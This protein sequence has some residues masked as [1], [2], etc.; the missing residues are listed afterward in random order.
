[1]SSSDDTHDP[2][3]GAHDPQMRSFLRQAAAVLAASRGWNDESHRKLRNLAQHFQLSDA[4]Y[5]AAI[6]HLQQS[7][8]APFQLNHWERDFVKQLT[9]TLEALRHQILKGS[10]EK[11]ILRIATEKYQIPELR[12]RQLL[13]HYAELGE[14]DRVR[15]EDAESMV[16]ETI[17]A[18]IQQRSTLA[19]HQREQLYRAGANWGFESVEV[20]EWILDRLRANRE[21]AR[22]RQSS[23]WPALLATGLVVVAIAGGLV[24]WNPLN[25]GFDV[26]S[27]R[28]AEETGRDPVTESVE[29]TWSQRLADRW[30]QEGYW[31]AAQR[32]RWVT[33]SPTERGEQFAEIVAG[34][35]DSGRPREPLPTMIRE[36]LLLEE[37][38]DAVR[39]VLDLVVGAGD[40]MS[41]PIPVSIAA[42]R[43]GMAAADW[44]ANWAADPSLSTLT[45]RT[46]DGR[47]W[48]LREWISD[49]LGPSPPPVDGDLEAW[50]AWARTTVAV[51][52]WSHTVSRCALNPAR[53]AALLEPLEELTTE[54]LAPI[55]LREFRSRVVDQVLELA[56]DQW[57]A[58]RESI[59]ASV[60]V[61]DP[62]QQQQWLVRYE[63]ASDPEW[64]RFL[65]DQLA[66][67]L[68]LES[69]GELDQQLSRAR[70][71]FILRQH[72]ELL[73]LSRE[74]DGRAMSLIAD[75]ARE[76]TDR[77]RQISHLAAS[78]NL[79]MAFE[80]ELAA[81]KSFADTHRRLE[82]GLPELAESVGLERQV[83][84]LVELRAAPSPRQLAE[85]TEL[86]Q[87]LIDPEA[88]DA[89]R[90]RALDQ[91]AATADEFDFLPRSESLALAR[92]ALFVE[93]VAG[94][95]GVEKNLPALTHWANLALAMGDLLVEEKVPLDRALTV[96]ALLT[97]IPAEDSD[98]EGN[99][100]ESVQRR[101]RNHAIRVLE[102]RRVRRPTPV[103][104]DWRRL[105]LWF[106]EAMADR[107]DLATGEGERRTLRAAV[108]Q[109][110]V[111]QIAGMPGLDRGSD[112][113][114][115]E[116]W[117]AGR[118]RVAGDLEEWLL[119]DQ[120]FCEALLDSSQR[121][122]R[123]LE[124]EWIAL[125]AEWRRLATGTTTV[126][127]RLAAVESILLRILVLRH[128]ARV[129]EVIDGI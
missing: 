36:W 17:D 76:G 91:I 14:V 83:D 66:A 114:N 44:L 88:S 100:R 64:K 1:M 71:D 89:S 46:A 105:Q 103:E 126:G 96:A 60:A 42:A 123:S 41:E 22:L 87:R 26:S 102:R 6:E 116:A 2:F 29:P 52:F 117:R 55:D 108:P 72:R 37:E 86:I 58:M 78:V 27:D 74:V 119:A 112:A 16:R 129:A 39:P 51:R 30:V 23:R 57:R 121:Q 5:G 3:P 9:G 53:A 38:G 12:A 77:P 32:D 7:R 97:A 127:E 49:N 104:L 113:I 48:G 61:A 80:K 94:G 115:A 54:Q 8:D 84:G 20:D 110:L 69:R 107:A 75:F 18:T 24:V 35:L 56:P 34:Q 128:R 70:R 19:R 15:P 111:E 82:A 67:R 99:W 31:S 21:A 92:Y 65:A 11:R 81:G 50:T 101:L 73:D 68:N 122:F 43:R 25:W 90:R 106:P 28:V 62:V 13:D 109:H 40:P 118:D 95:L 10:T 98:V 79:M 85:R 45:W 47:S 124:S 120:L 4:Q 59:A 93:D 125:D 33:A 63:S